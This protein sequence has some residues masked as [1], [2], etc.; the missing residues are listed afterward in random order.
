MT[1][2]TTLIA[3]CLVLPGCAVLDHE[4]S[5]VNKFGPQSM[6][7]QPVDVPDLVSVISGG[8]TKAAVLSPTQ[9]PLE[10]SEQ[11]DK[12]LRTF[13]TTGSAEDQMLRRNRLQDRLIL[14][15]NDACEAYKTVL[16]RKQADRNFQFGT[17]TVL[18]GAAG[19]VAHVA[20]TA[21][22]FAALS[23][24]SAG[25]HAEYNRD[26]YADVAAHIITKAIS[27]R[28]KEALDQIGQFQTL[29]IGKYT[30]EAA[31]ADS[32]VYHGACSLVGGLEYADGAVEK[33]NVQLGLDTFK[34][35]QATA[36]AIA[37]S[38]VAK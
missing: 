32:V 1:R 35:A 23:G 24:A 17:S 27:K 28:R 10:F 30:V 29:G 11:L 12:A 8:S 9:D 14:A 36:A 22:A 21:K 31:I 38:G 18:L 5:K 13:Y 6:L 7:Q 19:A 2:I 20:N 37:A 15:S 25:I 3:T 34:A 4:G 33:N 16:K 26:Y